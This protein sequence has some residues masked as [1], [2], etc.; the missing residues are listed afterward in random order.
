[1]AELT[2]YKK[3]CR[4]NG[5]ILI[6]GAAGQLGSDVVSEYG[7]RGVECMGIDIAELNIT[8]T[9]A[10]SAFL[11]LHKPACVIHCAAYT[12]VDRAED[13]KELCM[14]VNAD[15]TEN[16]ARA[17]HAIGAEMLYIST[18]YVFDG[19]GDAPFETDDPKAPLSVY[20]ES[21]F[22]GEMVVLR[23]LMKYY[24]VR[25]SWV[26]GQNGNNFVKTM[27]KLASGRNIINVVN[28]QYGSPTYTPDLADLL[29]DIALSGKYGV[30]HATNEGI[31]SWAEFAD[32]IMRQSGSG[33]KINPIPT[34]E[35]PTKAVRPSNSRM[36]KASLDSAGFTRLP[37]WKDAL[38]RYL[39]ER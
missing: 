11:R 3:R 27:L 28:D 8:D 13:E 21:K 16:L 36:S 24:I 1:M 2:D 14:R 33:C 6:T 26:F 37:D 31:C 25:I 30:Y 18:D 7:R 4:G 35:Y 38:R 22:A 12:A 39:D 15:G 23:N 20:G 5:L 9:D 19:D 10:V 34:S 29:C 17:C 32:E